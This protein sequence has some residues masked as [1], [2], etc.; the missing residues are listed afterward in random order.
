M[1]R[2]ERVTDCTS[3]GTRYRREVVTETSGAGGLYSVRVYRLCLCVCK[4]PKFL[5]STIVLSKGGLTQSC[6]GSYVFSGRPICTANTYFI[7]GTSGRSR[8]RAY[9]HCSPIQ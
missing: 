8:S 9:S 5:A 2:V 1:K 7:G 6:D 3:T 4:S